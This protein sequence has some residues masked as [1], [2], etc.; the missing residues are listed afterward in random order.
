MKV[1][2]VGLGKIG[3]PLA[4]HFALCGNEVFGIDVNPT[5]VEMVNGGVEPFPGEAE[6]SSSLS[7]AVRS[8]NLVATSDYRRAIMQS[9]IVV[10]TVPLMV[11]MERQPDF[12]VLES[13]SKSIGVNLQP[14][15]LIVVETTLPVGT[16]RNK[17]KP[18]LEQTSGLTE[19]SDFYLVYSPERVRT[20]R[21]FED[22]RKYPKLLG[23]LSEEGEQRA[24]QFYE[25]VI[26]FDKR[27]DLPRENGVWSLGP[28]E[29]AE[30]A[31]LA[32]TTYRDVN[33]ALANEFATYSERIGV[34]IHQII[35][36]CNSQPFSHLHDPGISVGG[37]CIPVY[38]QLF[39]FDSPHSN[40]VREARIVNEEMPER[41]L[42]RIQT[43]G[44]SFE[45]KS[46]VIL[47]VA[48]RPGVKETAYS[49]AFSL[50]TAVE[51]LGGH[52]SF[53][54]PLFSNSELRELGFSSADWRTAEYVILHTAHNAYLD[55]TKQDFPKAEVVFDGR[56]VLHKSDWIGVRFYS[57]GVG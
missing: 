57:L 15:T 47:G 17:I 13:A 21:V 22:L 20:G 27:E 45:G 55:V 41:I 56:N 7:K 4:V 9:N 18:L 25:S 51:E 12:R 31:K 3:L 16:I 50:R 52:P 42:R 30:L 1:S 14:D 44:Y 53:S 24:T 8:G 35:E 48:Y 49:G 23:S 32:E 43:D 46:V 38:P 36:G 5:T 10:V 2:V 34:D 39:L 54:D 19:G 6:L 40:M 11:D 37:H 26:S 33:I 29:A 28:P